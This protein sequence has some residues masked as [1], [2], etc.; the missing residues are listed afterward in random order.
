MIHTHEAGPV[1]FDVPRI[2]RRSIDQVIIDGVVDGHEE[3]AP[4]RV[5]TRIAF[6]GVRAPQGVF[7]DYKDALTDDYRFL[8]LVRR[9]YGY[10]PVIE[11]KTEAKVSLKAIVTG[12]A[13]CTREEQANTLY[14]MNKLATIVCELSNKHDG[15]LSLREVSGSLK[16]ARYGQLS[17]EEFGAFLEYMCRDPRFI[18][19]K[20]GR[21]VLREVFTGDPFEI[22][23]L[24]RID[25][26]GE[27]I[28]HA[29]PSIYL[30]RFGVFDEGTLLG[31]L[32]ALGIYMRT[33]QIT[34]LFEQLSLRPDIRVLGGDKY[35]FI[36]EREPREGEITPQNLTIDAMIRQ[37][38][39]RGGRRKP[40]SRKKGGGKYRVTSM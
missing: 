1:E 15:I 33:D 17:Y 8:D 16:N 30:G 20:D 22:E 19:L 5:L 13:R 32:K 4:L 28:D 31:T 26:L 10:Y 40:R 38:I 36:G 14:L 9:E 11:D 35:Q 27:V 24:K 39:G 18:V 3:R 12:K 34:E 23:E 37:A 25:N 6:G 21:F 7:L 29:I 2:T